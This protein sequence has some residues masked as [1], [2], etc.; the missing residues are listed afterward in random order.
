LQFHQYVQFVFHRQWS[1][2]KA[3]ANE[4]GISIIGDVPIFVSYDSADAWAHPELFHFDAQGRP[5]LV[6]GVPPDYFS[7]TGQL[8]GNPLYNWDAMARD[9][10]GWWIDRFKRA[11]QQVD[12]VRLDHFRGFE[13]CWAVPATEQTAINGKWLKSPGGELASRLAELTETSGRAPR[14]HSSHKQS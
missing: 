3:Y 8:W 1:G 13:A 2:L 11:F 10:Y 4:R 9:G 14:G 7:P 12:V 6:A 5:T